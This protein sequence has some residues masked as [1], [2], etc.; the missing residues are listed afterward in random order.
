[1]ETPRPTDMDAAHEA[2]QGHNDRMEF[3]KALNAKLFSA[4]I[5]DADV[6]RFFLCSIIPS[7]LILNPTIVWSQTDPNG[8]ISLLNRGF[9]GV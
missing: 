5:E 6:S 4:G 3:A 1:M 9:G 2:V 8:M 7:P